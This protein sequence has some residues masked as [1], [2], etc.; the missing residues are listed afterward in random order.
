M[1]ER[2]VDLLK[3]YLSA[4]WGYVIVSAG[5]F[6]ENSIA[7]GLVVPGE[8]LVVLGGFYARRGALSLPLV[9]VFACFAA[10]LGDNGGF[11]IGR[12]FGRGFVERRG[13]SVRITRGRLMQ[14]DAYYERHGAK[15]VFFG[16]FVPVLR[17]VSC[18]VAGISGMSWRR[19]ATYEVP[20][21]VIVQAEHAVLGYILGDAYGKATPFLRMVGLVVL[22]VLVLVTWVAKLR[23]TLK[24]AE[25][26][27]DEIAHEPERAASAEG[28]Q[29]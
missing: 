20:A 11:W 6:L 18:L 21:A 7:L 17:S 29:R 8:T 25:E 15:T 3:P 16:R 27:L 14:A 28:L 19:F 2:I 26:E 5:I 4:P 1:I 23:R 12:R 10:V 22:V 24:T 13:P 9:I